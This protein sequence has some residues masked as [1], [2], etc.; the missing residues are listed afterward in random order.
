MVSLHL[1]NNEIENQ[2]QKT[3]FQMLY[4]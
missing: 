3:I 4:W 2:M 1:Y